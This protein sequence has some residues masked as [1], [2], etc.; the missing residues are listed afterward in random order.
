MDEL[1]WK[2][3]QVYDD[4]VVVSW[5]EPASKEG[6]SHEGETSSGPFS[7]TKVKSDVTQTQQKET[8][9]S[10]QP[11]EWA[12]YIAISSLVVSMVAIGISIKRLR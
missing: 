4:G 10:G 5:D 6:H 2:A 1:E 7:V 9:S 11:G 3:Y 8:A 12:L